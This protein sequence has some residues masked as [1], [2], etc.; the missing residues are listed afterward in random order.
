MPTALPG[1]PLSEADYKMLERSFISP[2]L[3]ECASYS[4]VSDAEGRIV[5][6][7]NGRAGNYAGIVIPN[8]SP[9]TGYP[10]EYRLRRDT[11]DLAQRNGK[12]VEKGK[13]LSAPCARVYAYFVPGTR[14][15]WLTNGSLPV[16]IVEGEKKALAMW[17]VAWDGLGDAAEL[18]R[19]LPIGLS[20]VWNFRG[21]NGKAE[22]ANG[23]TRDTY[24]VI[25][26][27][28]NMGWLGRLVTILYDSN[29]HSNEDVRRARHHLA[30]WLAGEGAKVKLADLPPEE[31]INGPDDA[32]GKHGPQY[33]LDILE[34]AR[35]YDSLTPRPVLSHAERAIVEGQPYAGF[36]HD[37]ELFSRARLAGV[38]LDYHTVTGLVLMAGVLAG[39]LCTDTGLT[40]SLAIV[41]IGLQGIGKSL[42]SVIARDLISPIEDEEAEA[43]RSK[44]KDLK[45]ELRLKNDDDER[46]ELKEEI[47]RMECAGRPAII[48]ATQASVEGLLEA[49]SHQP[50]G[51]ID[52]DEFGAFLK[53]C[54]RQHMKSARE[55]FVKALDG[56]PVYYRRARGQS[57]DIPRPVLSLWGTINVG[58]LRAIATDEDLL[59]G[60]FSRIPFCAPDYEFSFPV[61]RPGDPQKTEHLKSVLRR[62]RQMQPKPVAFAEGVLERSLDYGYA[63]APYSKGDRVD[64][65]EPDDGI[66]AVA[67]V[68]YP[69]LAQKLAILFAASECEDDAEHLQVEMRHILLAIAFAEKLR[70]YSIRIL[71]HLKKRDTEVEDADALLAKIVKNPGRKRGDYQRLMHGWGAARFNSAMTELEA[72]SRVNWE[73]TRSTGGRKVRTYFPKQSCES[74]ESLTH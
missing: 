67:Y 59:G 47:A 32:A 53:D 17:A 6:G 45:R 3:A 34:Q 25:A 11:P 30:G 33:V 72:S 70:Q 56:R 29:V 21:R 63:I 73:D 69:T 2:E 13:Y 62:W 43:H 23:G 31:G 24:G 20:G 41:T 39:S 19:F 71:Q 28:Q 15:E 9:T 1:T 49:L 10:R 27:L 12:L 48:I 26:D 57:V 61:L 18:P 46:E 64:I 74:C 37:Y 60:F 58:S 7:A 38:P 4:R 42:P 36:L 65:T 55:N 51:I 16:V 5:V 40:P 68:R 52:F 22:A 14:P 8:I 44:L 54:E 66:G 50:C 35:I